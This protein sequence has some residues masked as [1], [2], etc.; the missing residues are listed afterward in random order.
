MLQTT[1]EKNNEP[2]PHCRRLRCE[3]DI[4]R[5]LHIFPNH[6]AMIGKA[7]ISSLTLRWNCL[8]AICHACLA[9]LRLLRV[10]N[11]YDRKGIRRTR[12]LGIHK[13]PRFLHKH[14]F[15]GLAAAEENRGEGTYATLCGPPS[16]FKNRRFPRCAFGPDS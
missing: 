14:S 15:N 10:R 6:A 3:R 5:P 16:S 2:I 12:H 8:L 4:M 9:L 13:A 7:Q 11:Y 1:D